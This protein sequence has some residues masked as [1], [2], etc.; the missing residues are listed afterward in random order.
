MSADPRLS[1]TA[2]PAPPPSPAPRR[3]TR[4]RWINVRVVVG[5][6]LV[7]GS[8]L[9]GAR[10]LAADRETTQIWSVGVDLAAGAVL[11]E[12]DLE[13]R[14]V[15]LGDS[16]AAY[17]L[18]DGLSPVGQELN[19]PVRAGELLPAAAVGIPTEGRVVVLPVQPDRLPAGVV[20]GSTVDIYLQSGRGT[21]EVGTTELLREVTVQTVDA[22]AGGLGSVAGTV[23][24]SVSLTPDQA[25]ELVPRLAEGDVLLVLVTGR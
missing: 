25:R 23:Q 13:V 22:G 10:F 20:H 21:A 18:A 1:P 19:R 16:A 5:L 9:A 6:L 12:T 14:D 2:P 7:V 17:L 3:W 4:P 11:G 8:V 15:R 24:V